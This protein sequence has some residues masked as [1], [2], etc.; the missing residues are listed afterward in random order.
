MLSETTE[1]CRLILLRHPELDPGF[2][3][4]AVG[5]GEAALGRRGQA[6]V[7]RWLQL[8]EKIQISTIYC[9][10]QPQ[11]A[12]PARALGTHKQVDVVDD[13][14]LNDQSMGTWQGRAWDDLAKEEGE[15]V[16]DFFTNFGETSAPQGE[17]LGEALERMLGWWQEIAPDSLQKTLTIVTT[18]SMISGF[19]TAML[20]MRLSRCVSL[21][22]PHGGLGI[23]DCFGNGARITAWNPTVLEELR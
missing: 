6:Q 10:A 8:F 20:G 17:S 15:T 7:L 19:A 1:F 11:C 23:L 2:A 22:L 13:P 16:R 18:G 4:L 3:N 21:N 14:R 9:A 12:D 5:D